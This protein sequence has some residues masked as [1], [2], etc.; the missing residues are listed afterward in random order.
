MALKDLLIPT[1]L[2]DVVQQDAETE[3][4]QASTLNALSAARLNTVQSN[5]I[6]QMLP[7][8]LAKQGLEITGMGLDNTS[9]QIGNETA[10]VQQEGFGLDNIMKQEQI[11]QQIRVGKKSE[12]E[13]KYAEEN[14]QLKIEEQKAAIRL[15]NAQIAEAA[16]AT[17]KSLL[18]MGGE[19]QKQAGVIYPKVAKTMEIATRLF[20]S[21]D[22]EG[23][24][25][26][27]G[28]MLQTLPPWFREGEGFVGKDLL[29]DTLDPKDDVQLMKD[30]ATYAQMM[31]SPDTLMGQMT[32]DQANNAAE[33]A[34]TRAAQAP[35]QQE[36]AEVDQKNRKE[37]REAYKFMAPRV[38][39]SI[40]GSEYKKS[41][42]MNDN[43]DIIQ[44]HVAEPFDRI[45]ALAAKQSVKGNDI[46]AGLAKQFKMGSIP[47]KGLGNDLDDVIVP[48]PRREHRGTMTAEQSMQADIEARIAKD[49]NL[50]AEQAY[51]DIMRERVSQY[52]SLFE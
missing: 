37:E 15:K 45:T 2:N 28:S 14:E 25:R 43:G 17:K 31:A 19:Y 18:E 39:S 32:R 24:N 51:V 36:Q 5:R 27:Y 6:E 4:T 35:T 13:L 48:A 21:G 41:Q 44:P 11:N 10:L 16:Q 47:I 42:L 33:L 22:V 3:Q 40:V 29:G 50:T 46:T 1:Y 12:I 7:G 34:K 38:A 49:Q 26:L 30:F 23:A 9:K 52:I 20:E 8:E